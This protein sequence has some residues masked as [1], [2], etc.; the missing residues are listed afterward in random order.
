[1]SAPDRFAALFR[2]LDRAHGVSVPTGKKDAR[3]K[4]G[5]RYVTKREP[6]GLGDWDKHLAGEHCLVPIPIRDDGTCGFGAIDVDTYPLDLPALAKRVEELKLPLVVCRSKSGGAHL[7]LFLEEPTDAQL[8]QDVLLNW[9]SALGYPGVEVFPKQVSLASEVDTGNGIAAPYR[10]GG[11]GVEYALSPDDG[12]ALGVEAFLD[13]AES[14]RTSAPDLEQVELPSDPDMLEGAPPCLVHWAKSGIPEGGRNETMFDFGV[15]ARKRW[16]DDWQSRFEELNRRYCDPPLPATEI[17][18]LVKSIQKEGKTY[19]YKSKCEGPHCQPQLCRRAK[20]G[21]GGGYDDPGAVIDGL[22]KILTDPA[23][24]IVS[25]NGQ[26]VELDSVAELDDQRRFRLKVMEKTVPP[27]RVRPMKPAKWGELIDKLTIECEVVEAPEDAGPRGQILSHLKD[28]VEQY[29]TED[30]DQID[31]DRPWRDRDHGRVWFRSKDLM[32]YL[33]KIR[34][35]GHRE[36]EL[37]NAIR[38]VGGDH[39][40]LR[41]RGRV[42]RCWWV[43]EWDEPEK[44]P[45]KKV[46]TRPKGDEVPF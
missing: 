14:R 36:R 32:A 8:V 12:T 27:I 33:R 5:A 42:T 25:V 24:W 37:Y 10:G 41:V 9:A 22:T 20:Y 45:L 15:Y 44:E 30:R 6:A 34:V 35:H 43:P 26:R 46:D 38:A 21:K 2:G 39:G 23:T 11:D 16:P 7:F 13:L 18:Q 29:G 1:M 31:L 19:L 4:M 17:V 3:G 28:F 40:P